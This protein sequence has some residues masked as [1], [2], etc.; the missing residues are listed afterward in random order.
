MLETT[1]IFIDA[2]GKAKSLVTGLEI[3]KDIK[4]S[5]CGEIDEEADK[6]E[7]KLIELSEQFFEIISS[8][9]TKRVANLILNRQ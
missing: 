9:E 5:I 4:N 6:A 8:I 3:E 2:M 1:T 7:L